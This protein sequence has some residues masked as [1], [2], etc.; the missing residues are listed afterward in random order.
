ML[1][2]FWQILCHYYAGPNRSL[3]HLYKKVGRSWSASVRHLVT[4]SRQSVSKNTYP[5]EVL[6]TDILYNQGKQKTN[7]KID[8]FAN[9]SSKLI[10]V[11]KN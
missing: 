9:G 8:R 2:L 1:K 5:V 3:M 7:I 11:I 4:S 10:R 6:I